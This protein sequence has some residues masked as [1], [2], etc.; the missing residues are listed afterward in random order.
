MVAVSGRRD[1]RGSVRRRG[2]VGVLLSK[3]L[4]QSW[5]RT[6]RVVYRILAQV[7]QRIKRIRVVEMMR[8]Q[9]RLG[10][11]GVSDAV[12]SQTATCQPEIEM[13]GRLESC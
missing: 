5:E 2:V 4:I 11:V 3:G 13:V 8:C 10:E 12:G 6:C 7:V 9:R 1:F